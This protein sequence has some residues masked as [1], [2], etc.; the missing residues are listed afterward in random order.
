[1]NH[2][3]YTKPFQGA[4]AKLLASNYLLTVTSNRTRC[5][6][7]PASRRHGDVPQLDAGANRLEFRCDAPART[8]PRAYVT[9]MAG[10]GIVRGA[11]PANKLKAV[12]R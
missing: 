2:F 11:N 12:K 4:R 3:K 7:Q 9:V 10:G 5:L 1:M 6:Q 8:N